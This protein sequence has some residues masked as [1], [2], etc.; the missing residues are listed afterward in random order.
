VPRLAD[1]R[2]VSHKAGFVA[3]AP[4]YL[5]PTLSHSF[6]RGYELTAG[7]DTRPALRVGYRYKSED[8]YAGVSATTWLDAPLASPGIGVAGDGV[9]YT[10]VGTSNKADHVWWV[11]DKVL[12]WVSNTL[13]AELTAEQLLAMA[14]SAVP[15]SPGG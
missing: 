13:F 8:L 4:S 2:F 10:V 1:W 11:K 15:V 5:P 12:Y 6:S 9:V 14:I 3:M 7:D